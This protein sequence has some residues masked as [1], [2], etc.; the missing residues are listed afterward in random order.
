MAHKKLSTTQIDNLKLMVVEGVYP[1][2]IAH[3]FNI[4][5]SSVHN[6]K[7]RFKIQ[8]L[9]FP[10]VRGKRPSGAI[11]PAD[12]IKNN[13]QF[14]PGINIQ[15]EKHHTDHFKVMING[16]LVEISAGVKYISIEKEHMEIRF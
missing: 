6:Y 15:P 5:V 1:E 14:S 10:T 12:V 16:V 2:D 9:K 8:G 3:Y 13:H 11:K 7:N 4:A